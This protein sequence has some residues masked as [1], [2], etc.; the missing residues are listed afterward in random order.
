MAYLAE[1]GEIVVVDIPHYFQA[2]PIR[3]FLVL[4]PKAFN[5]ALGLSWVCPIFGDE[6]KHAFQ[7]LLPSQLETFGVVHVE[8]LAA[9]NLEKAKY[10]E[11]VPEDFLQ[12][13]KEIAG[14][15]LG[16]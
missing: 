1:E 8:G 15:V 14:R 2:T 4:S 16:F 12:Q 3:Q 10:V 9:I 13:C 11:K 6:D 7:R 5:D